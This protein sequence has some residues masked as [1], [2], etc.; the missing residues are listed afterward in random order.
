MIWALKVARGE[1]NAG[2]SCE[3]VPLRLATPTEGAKWA[4]P[5]VVQVRGIA[6]RAGAAAGRP[7]IVVAQYDPFVRLAARPYLLAA[8]RPPEA[9]IADV[10][11]D[12]VQW[13]PHVPD[14]QVCERHE[15]SAHVGPVYFPLHEHLES[16]PQVPC[17]PQLALSLHLLPTSNVHAV[18]EPSNSGSHST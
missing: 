1:A 6:V 8:V 2:L 9:C 7:G 12:P 10:Q 4:F 14:S 18:N 16:G 17:A 3:S 15:V 5:S 13:R 11:M